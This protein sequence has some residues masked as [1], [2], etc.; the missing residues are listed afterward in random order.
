MALLK[1]LVIGMGVLIVLGM[2]LLA[3]GVYS[4]TRGG[5]AAEFEAAAFGDILVDLGPGCTLASVTP[6]GARVWLRAEGP[7][8]ACQRVIAV[9]LASGRTLG[10][11]G[12]QP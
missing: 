1:G 3:W 2:G 4:K 9:D 12:A 8:P 5:A 10:S 6:D 7:A 11:I